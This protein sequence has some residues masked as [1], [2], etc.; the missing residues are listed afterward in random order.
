[1]PEQ[2]PALIEDT[3][4]QIPPYFQTLPETRVAHVDIKEF[5]VR[6]SSVALI[7]L[8]TDTY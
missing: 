1:M 2:M 3:L 5:K 7:E 4:A 8:V 6:M